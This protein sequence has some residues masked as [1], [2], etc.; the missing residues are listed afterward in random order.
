M[1]HTLPTM[2]Q[3]YSLS[4]GFIQWL[5]SNKNRGDAGWRVTLQWGGMTALSQPSA[6]ATSTAG[7]HADKIGGPWYNN[8]TLLL[9]SSLQNCNPSGIVRKTSDKSYKIPKELEKLLK[10]IKVIKISLR[11]YHRQEK[12][13]KS[14]WLNVTWYP[15]MR[16]WPKKRHK[17]KKLR[18]SE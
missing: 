7:S 6:K 14:W 12:P 18:K 5:L 11:N 13:K 15:G 4:K 8:S 1:V 3:I 9:W 17:V 2:V 10:T 16:S